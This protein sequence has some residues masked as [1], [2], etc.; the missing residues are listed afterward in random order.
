M[1]PPP[2]F[3]TNTIFVWV[4][5]LRQGGLEVSITEAECCRSYIFH[6]KVHS[7]VPWKHVR[8]RIMV[9][10]DVSCLCSEVERGICFAYGI[11]LPFGTGAES[12]GNRH[13]KSN[14]TCSLL[15]TP[16]RSRK[17][18]QDTFNM[19]LTDS[20]G[21]SLSAIGF[22]TTDIPSCKVTPFADFGW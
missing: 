22:Y 12:S 3:L 14:V 6:N 10:T 9:E 1:T 4:Y 8:P 5:T 19:E 20:Y 11:N 2:L 13:N 18:P 7:D 17:N 15:P 21:K 16:T